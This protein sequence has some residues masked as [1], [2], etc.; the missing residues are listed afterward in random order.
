MPKVAYIEDDG[1]TQA[2]PVVVAS[3]PDPAPVVTPQWGPL[4]NQSRMRVGLTS[5]VTSSSWHLYRDALRTAYL[6][7]VNGGPGNQPVFREQPAAHG[8]YTLVTDVPCSV[9]A[10]GAT[11]EQVNADGTLF[12][13]TVPQGGRDLT[14]KY[15][16]NGQPS[17]DIKA[18]LFRPGYTDDFASIFT[19]EAKAQ[20]KPFGG[21]RFMDLLATN[22]NPLAHWEDRP[23]EENPSV[24]GKT[25][26][27]LEVCFQ[28]CNELGK[29]CYINIPVNADDGYILGLKSLAES[30]LRPDVKCVVEDVNELWH[31][32]PPFSYARNIRLEQMRAAIAAGD[33]TLTDGMPNESYSLWA[34]LARRPVEIAKL[35]GPRFDV[36]LAGQHA[37]SSVLK[38][39]LNYVATYLGPPKDFF[40]AIVT[41]PYFYMPTEYQSR[42]DLTPQQVVEIMASQVNYGADKRAEHLALAQQYGLAFDAYEC[43]RHLHKSASPQAVIEA[44]KTTGA[45][46]VIGQNMRNHLNGGM[47]NLYYFVVGS[48]WG[49]KPPDQVSVWG[50]TPG[51]HRSSHT[52]VALEDVADLGTPKMQ[53]AVRVAERVQN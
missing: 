10:S 33:T 52:W 39:G 42:V 7:G 40:K 22:G 31:S 17:N 44:Q 12:R 43:G 25:G 29:D 26:H 47:R 3:A 38:T 9:T 18:K 49:F 13:V 8:A 5:Q 34:F 32:A 19:D 37:N 41:A 15:K 51:T 50:A 14:L 36:V 2:F 28:L 45:A 46:E 16:R 24:D 23:T 27:P 1:T 30:M 48:T 21:I 35:L 20:L 53:A 6:I 4:S 11:V